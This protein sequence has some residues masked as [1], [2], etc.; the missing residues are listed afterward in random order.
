MPRT[1]R[2]AAS[3]LDSRSSWPPSSLG[4]A[5][6]SRRGRP[7]GAQPGPRELRGRGG[8]CP[9]G[10]C[11]SRPQ[12]LRDGRVHPHRRDARGPWMPRSSRR[13]RRAGGPP[14]TG[15]RSSPPV[16]RRVPEELRRP[17]GDLHLPRGRRSRWSSRPARRRS[18]PQQEP[19][20]TVAGDPV[21]RRRLT[22]GAATTHPESRRRS[23][24]GGGWR[25]RRDR[26]TFGPPARFDS[27]P[28]QQLGRMPG[29][30]E[31]GYR[32]GTGFVVAR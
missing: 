25:F 15:T 10:P 2:S 22:R 6:S 8:E 26:P 20:R 16:R 11:G 19:F 21:R 30:S 12:I 14:P 1:V 13:P 17:G 29:H 18:I 7:R 27:V 31:I 32:A 28:V 5:A 4:A 9:Q 23:A 24:R 3:R